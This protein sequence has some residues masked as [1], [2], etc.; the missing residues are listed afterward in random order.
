VITNNNDHYTMIEKAKKYDELVKLELRPR[1]H[2]SFCGRD[3]ENVQ[4]LIAGP[5]VYICDECVSLCNEILED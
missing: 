2:C 5:R 1:L 4:K 3:Q